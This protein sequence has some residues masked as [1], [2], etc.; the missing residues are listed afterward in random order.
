M[1]TRNINNYINELL[2]EVHEPG[3]G[4][5][6]NP[7]FEDL[8]E[9]DA[10]KDRQM[11]PA[12]RGDNVQIVKDRQAE[13]DRR[14][15]EAEKEAA[16]GRRFFDPTKNPMDGIRDD[17]KSTKKPLSSEERELAILRAQAKSRTNDMGERLAARKALK[18]MEN[19]AAPAKTIGDM[20]KEMDKMRDGFLSNLDN[21]S[22]GKGITDNLQASGSGKKPKKDTPGREIEKIP[23]E[24]RPKRP[25]AAQKPMPY[26]PGRRPDDGTRPMRPIRDIGGM[27][28]IADNTFDRRPADPRYDD[29]RKPIGKPIEAGTFLKPESRESF[30]SKGGKNKRLARAAQADKTG[31]AYMAQVMG[32]GKATAQSEYQKRIDAAKDREKDRM[33]N[34]PD[35]RPDSRIRDT[36][37]RVGRDDQNYGPPRTGLAVYDPD[38]K[39]EPAIPLGRATRE[40]RQGDD[41]ISARMN[42]GSNPQA[43]PPRPGEKPRSLSGEIQSDFI[44]PQKRKRMGY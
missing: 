2:N 4:A 37:F 22:S 14:R 28:P 43:R 3:H 5:A 34:S 13:M 39:Y 38:R 24:R 40:R 20:G 42:R 41:R 44:N 23:V 32:Q 12:Q 8:P 18:A 33:M 9:L 27:R 36:M 17:Q 15:R 26:Y 7:R 1:A 6:F 16:D 30:P 25:V 31:D 10:E 11:Y 21:F 35:A 19:Q 29:I